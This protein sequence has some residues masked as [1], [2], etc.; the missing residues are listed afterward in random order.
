MSH[1]LERKVNRQVLR[2]MKKN[3]DDSLYTYLRKEHNDEKEYQEFKFCLEAYKEEL[4][5]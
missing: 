4:N 3:M 1:R 5:K 2:Q